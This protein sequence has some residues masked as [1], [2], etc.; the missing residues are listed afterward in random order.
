MV[1]MV[2]VDAAELQHRQNTACRVPNLVEANLYF[3]SSLLK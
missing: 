2:V 3:D 1:M